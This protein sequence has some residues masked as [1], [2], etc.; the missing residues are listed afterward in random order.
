MAKADISSTHPI[1]MD[2]KSMNPIL[3]PFVIQFPHGS[4]SFRKINQVTLLQ[5]FLIDCFLG[6]QFVCKACLGIPS[7]IRPGEVH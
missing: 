4:T 3:Q 1:Y 7:T 5:V 2:P 6:K